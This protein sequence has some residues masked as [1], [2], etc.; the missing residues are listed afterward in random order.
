MQVCKTKSKKNGKKLYPSLFS[1][2]F[3]HIHSISR[4]LLHF[5][6]QDNRSLNFVNPAKNVNFAAMKHAT[7]IS[8]LA[9]LLLAVVSCA[10]IGSPEGGPRDFAP[11]RVTRINP[12]Q[13][14]V[15]FKGNKIEISFNEIVTI[16]DQQKKVSVSPVQAT[17]PLI[18]SL[19]KKITVELRD[20]LIPDATYVVDFA[21][22]IEDNNEGNQLDGFAVTF[23]TGDAIDT[24]QV[25]GIVLRGRDL[26]PM[27][28][29]LVGLH[30]CLDDSAFTTLPFDRVTRTNS[31]GQFTIMGIGAGEYRIFAL[32]DVDG[33]HRMN[34]TEN[35]A[36]VDR[37]IVPETR[38]FTSTDTIFTFDHRV[39]TILEREHTEFLPNNV[40]LTMFNEDYRARY[41][42]THAR[43]E[44]NR[45]HILFSAPADTLPILNILSPRT[46]TRHWAVVEHTET[47]D[48]I[49]YWLTDSTLIGSDSI[50]VEMKHLRTDPDTDTLAWATDTL[51]F[52]YR[53]SPQ[54]IREEKEEKKEAEQ[55]RRRLE[56]IEQKQAQGKELNEEE[57]ED[58][59]IARQPVKPRRIALQAPKQGPVDIGDSIIITSTVP[60][61]SIDPH[62]IHL[63]VK[64]DTLW[65]PLPDAPALVPA[66]ATSRMRYALPMRLEPDSSYRL[67]VDSLAV[68][69]IYGIG[70][71]SLQFEVK[72]KP[73][74][75]YASLA[76]QV[77][78][79]TDSAVVE[80]LA[81]GEKIVATA[82][83][84]GGEAVFLFVKP[85]TYYARLFI[86]SNHNGKW[87]TG[88]YSAHIQPEDVYYYPK[89]LVMR[90]NWDVDQ[91]WNIAELPLD[92]QKPQAI[93]KNKPEKSKIE[94]EMENRDRRARKAAGVPEDEDDDEFNSQGFSRTGAYSGNK[95]QD[96]R[97]NRNR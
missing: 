2:L 16:K 10:N 44:P 94:Q 79:A 8:L 20:T 48:S 60:I 75:D 53:K 18:R 74:E 35:Y 54:Q 24:M 41:F 89:P 88:K 21:N 27:Q 70:C 80:L 91:S 69:S 95:Y 85:G 64:R 59:R 37:I 4:T 67:T 66:P 19:G 5:K 47:N 93:R 26:E 51:T 72:V 84:T 30:S 34:R 38:S 42:K 43:P 36:F 12:P 81:S 56:Q 63:C 78:G 87:D 3:L 9:A 25:S 96:Y 13:G 28:H 90:R 15:N 62:R 73:V 49:F 52:A 68:T 45:L 17:M 40:L 76:L 86:D 39:D 83:V 58:L 32:N 31:L 6:N 7:L 11:P 82:P 55:L 1:S 92:L 65:E 50:I 71:D 33:D 57:L 14:T 23:S 22:A 61:G 29:V 97:N 46:A 77:T